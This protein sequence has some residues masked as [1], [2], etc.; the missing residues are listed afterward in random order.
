MVAPINVL[1]F[2]WRYHYW[3]TN[4]SI[5]K[6]TEQLIEPAPSQS[7]VVLH[8]NVHAAMSRMANQ[9]QSKLGIVHL[10]FL[11]LRPAYMP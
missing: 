1:A 10:L 9:K 11:L 7:V 8:T 5:E 6:L 2:T 4:V 3:R